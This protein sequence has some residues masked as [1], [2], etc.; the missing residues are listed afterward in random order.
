MI[1]VQLVFLPTPRCL[2]LTFMQ[3]RFQPRNVC[4]SQQIQT[5]VETMQFKKSTFDEQGGLAAC[6]NAPVTAQHT[7]HTTPWCSLNLNEWHKISD[8]ISHRRTQWYL[9]VY[10]RQADAHNT[11]CSVWPVVTTAINVCLTHWP[12]Y[13]TRDCCADN[14]N[15]SAKESKIQPDLSSLLML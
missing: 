13:N 15:A 10:S 3:A 14:V 12:G 4:K 8:K 11:E 2:K 1:Y 5:Y 6:H 9:H 7:P